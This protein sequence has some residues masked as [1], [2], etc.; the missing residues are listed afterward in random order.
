MMAKKILNEVANI[1]RL[2]QNVAQP[3]VGKLVILDYINVSFLAGS[4]Y[5]R[6]L[7]LNA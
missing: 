4:E 1:K 7:C 3:T 2:A 6:W 5:Q